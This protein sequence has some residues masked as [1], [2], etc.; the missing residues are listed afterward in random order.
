MSVLGVVH[1]AVAE[2]TNSVV[3]TFSCFCI[4][5]FCVNAPVVGLSMGKYNFVENEE[6]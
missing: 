3:Y 5:C 1:V 2:L 6:I 4:L